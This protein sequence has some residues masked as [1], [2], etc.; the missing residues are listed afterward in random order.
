MLCP[1][2][3]HAHRRLM[4]WVVAHA[5]VQVLLRSSLALHTWVLSG[6]AR[7]HRQY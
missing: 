7:S 1:G 3:L 2:A 6:R 4:L 5:L